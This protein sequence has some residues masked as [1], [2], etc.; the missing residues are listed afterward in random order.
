M[1]TDKI[2]LVGF[3]AAGKTSLARAVGARLDWRVEDVDQLIEAR[4]QLAVAEI[5][6]RRGE[7]YFRQVERNIVQ[8]LLPMRHV[9]VATGGGTF[10]APE[11]RAAIKLDGL[12]AWIDVPFD[13]LLARIPPDGS[14]PLAADTRQVA[15]L[16]RDRRAAYQ[17]AHLRLEG[18][19]TPIDELADQ[20]VERLTREANTCDISS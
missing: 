8:L 16:Y 11:T 13:Q 12:C 20:L 5:F 9:V 18:S 1:T 14:R 6:E 19:H 15:Q 4:E 10:M 2:Y 3:M 7:P 17:E